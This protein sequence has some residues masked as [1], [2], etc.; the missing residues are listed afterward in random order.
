M[1]LRF[2]P[3]VSSRTRRKGLLFKVGFWA[4]L[5]VDI[6]AI[7]GAH[8]RVEAFTFSALTL[9]NVAVMLHITK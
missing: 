8:D 5:I 1:K 7:T 3:S 2:P 9:I 6:L 4:L